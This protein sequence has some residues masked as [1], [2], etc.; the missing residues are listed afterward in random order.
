LRK[1]DHGPFIENGFA[2][3]RIH[4][5]CARLD[6]SCGLFQ[7]HKANGLMATIKTSLS[8]GNKVNSEFFNAGRAKKIAFG[9]SRSFTSLQRITM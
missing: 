7:R 3:A 4:L 8:A 1:R 9:N 5:A 6:A 2:V